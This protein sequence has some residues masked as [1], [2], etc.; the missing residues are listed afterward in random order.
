M[1][2]VI[3]L[4]GEGGGVFEMTL[5]LNPHIAARYKAHQLVR[6]NPDGSEYQRPEGDGTEGDEDAQPPKRGRA[7]SPASGA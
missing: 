3:Y 4:R 5:P 6:V 2:G 1:S 7:K